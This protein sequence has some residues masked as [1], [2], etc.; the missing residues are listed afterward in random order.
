[1]AEHIYFWTRHDK[2]GYCSNFWRAA[3]NI[4]GKVYPTTEHYYQA[5]KTLI[6]EEHEM[7]RNLPT[8]KEAKFAGYHVTLRDNWDDI[9]LDVMLTALS[10]KFSQHEDLAI[11]LLTTG[12]AELHENSPWDKF[13][14]YAD[15][16]GQDYLGK[17]L[18]QVRD[19]LKEDSNEN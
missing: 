11:R 8:P 14:G 18:M 5:S 3:V 19:K 1:M 9:K 13:W 6:P 7:I 10:A 16:K 4:D 17:L 2:H 12:N 15:G